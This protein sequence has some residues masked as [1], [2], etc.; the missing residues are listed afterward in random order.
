MLSAT[1]LREEKDMKRISLYSLMIV[2]IGIT[3]HAEAASEWT[4]SYHKLVT[5]SDLEIQLESNPSTGFDWYVVNSEEQYLDYV[6]LEKKEFIAEQ[7]PE[8]PLGAPGITRFVYR[9]NQPIDSLVLLFSYQRPWEPTYVSAYHIAVVT[10]IDR[11]TR[12]VCQPICKNI[13]HASEGWY[14]SCTNELI[15]HGKCAGLSQ[16][17]CGALKTRSEGWYSD[18]GLSELL[19]AK[20]PSF[21]Y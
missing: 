9:A 20:A 8:S 15:K 21:Q 3:S 13:G 11:A 18:H 14:S 7:D 4:R 6:A 17:F 2:F 12:R 5:G 16:P 1:E 10:I 19:G